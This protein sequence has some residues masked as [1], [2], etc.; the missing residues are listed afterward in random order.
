M[1]SL[2]VVLHRTRRLQLKMSQIAVLSTYSAHTQ[3][4]PS[5][6]K[7]RRVESS[8]I[9]R[10]LSLQQ[11]TGLNGT[12]MDLYHEKVS[13]QLIQY[14][15]DQIP[16]VH[17]LQRLLDEVITYV[18]PSLTLVDEEVAQRSQGEREVRE[19][20]M[21]LA[22]EQ[23]LRESTRNLKDST[24]QNASSQQFYDKVLELE[25]QKEKSIIKSTVPMGVY[26]HGSV[27]C[28]KTMLM[29]LF[30][31]ALLT[32]NNHVPVTRVHFHNFMRD[33]FKN[34]HELQNLSSEGHKYRY[35]HNLLRPMAKAIAKQATVLCFDEMQIP[36][37][38]TAAILYRLFSCLNEYGV[39]VVGTGNRA[40]QELY[41]G[42][43]NDTLFEPWVNMM[44]D[45]WHVIELKSSRD[46]RREM[47]EL[48]SGPNGTNLMSRCFFTPLNASSKIGMDKAWDSMV[49]SK[50]VS[51]STVSV[52][53]RDVVIPRCTSGRGAVARFAFADL[54]SKA[55]GSSDYLAIA[56]KFATIFVD[57]IPQMTMM[58]RNEARRFISLVDALYECRT[59]LFF[60]AAQTPDKMFVEAEDQ[61]TNHFDI[62]FREML[63]DMAD[64]LKYTG[65]TFK[66]HLFTGE[67][68]MFASKRCVSRLHEMQT[69]AYRLSQHQPQFALVGLKS[70]LLDFES[71][72]SDKQQTCSEQSSQDSNAEPT[73]ETRPKFGLKHFW[74]AGWWELKVKEKSEQ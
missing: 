53:A 9:L 26:I 54:C 35:D 50:D 37:I 13:E 17:S 38:G 52:F 64:E 40:P 24:A 2:C 8:R 66:S 55:L 47:F 61:L 57:D 73:K 70:T 15:E 74:G 42:H 62:M 29:D 18:P 28:G 51:Q 33:I 1:E 69:V 31:D 63:G 3:Y 4:N 32:T 60:S 43:F 71:P 30:F 68:E 16:I 67:E 48:G 41:R 72:E 45:K 11:T 65:D 20:A 6:G 25:E 12:I 36:D 46:F 44:K 39:V 49:A 59:K 34:Y 21:L 23:K 22:E 19:F 58:R 27:G 10:K 5:K 56:N 7:R 14:D